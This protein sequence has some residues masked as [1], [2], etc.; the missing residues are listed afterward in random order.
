MNE[1]LH[2]YLDGELPLDALTPAERAEAEEWRALMADTAELRS[3]TAPPWIETRVMATLPAH[4]H[5]SWLERGF[6]WAT[7]PQPLRVRPV[8]LALVGA[9]AALVLFLARPQQPIN[10]PAL[11]PSATNV[12]TV[13]AS[14]PAIIYV[15]FVLADRNAKAVS[16]AGEFNA[17][18]PD[19]TPLADPDGDGVWTGL[20]A[21]RPGM[22]KYMFVV[23]GKQWVTDPQAE[24]YIEDGFG[25]R[26][27]VISVTPPAAKT[28]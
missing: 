8:S 3:V 23:D 12:Q 17:W 14:T 10:E 2:K 7:A 25:M 11:L 6:A 24:R 16:V 5:R 13:S 28:I 21:L 27:A 1:K 22:H 9:A 20:V 4:P 15:Q 19:S 26:N 18:D